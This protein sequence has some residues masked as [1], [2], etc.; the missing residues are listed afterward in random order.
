MTQYDKICPYRFQQGYQHQGG[1]Q[2]SSP[3]ESFC[4]GN[5]C[6]LWVEASWDGQKVSGCAKWVEVQ[7]QYLRYDDGKSW[8]IK[9]N[10]LII[11]EKKKKKRSLMEFGLK[12]A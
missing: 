9:D 6:G 1:Y 7:L 8:K 4:K 2:H 10:K 5:N 3:L 12:D 11:K